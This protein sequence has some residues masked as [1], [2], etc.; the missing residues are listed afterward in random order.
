MI[1]HYLVPGLGWAK[2]LASHNQHLSIRLPQADRVFHN[3]AAALSNRKTVNSLY[4]MLNPQ[5]KLATGL[6]TLQKSFSNRERI[7]FKRIFSPLV[8]R[9]FLTSV[10]RGV[11]PRFPLTLETVRLGIIQCD[12]LTYETSLPLFVINI[13]FLPP[14]F[15]NSLRHLWSSSEGEHTFSI[16]SSQVC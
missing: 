6:E 4:I 15:R 13:I 3:T 10:H 16:L 5:Q 12:N 7:C 1:H 8:G 9:T 11:L 2:L 14:D